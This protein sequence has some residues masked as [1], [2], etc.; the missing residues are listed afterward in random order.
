MQKKDLLL[1][2]LRALVD[3]PSAPPNDAED[4][5]LCAVLALS[6]A[7]AAA[8]AISWAPPRQGAPFPSLKNVNLF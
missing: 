7:L 5:N 8:L 6:P 4:N 3:V 1:S 2:L